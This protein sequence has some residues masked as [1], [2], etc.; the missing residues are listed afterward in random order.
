MVGCVSHEMKVNNSV[1]VSGLAL[2]F[3]FVVLPVTFIP[4][5]SRTYCSCLPHCYNISRLSD[6][7]TTVDH[8]IVRPPGSIVR[9]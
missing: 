4:S 1:L 6:L 8:I 9:P 5:V 7:P 2:A 3:L